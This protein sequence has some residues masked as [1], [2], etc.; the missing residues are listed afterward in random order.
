MK[1]NITKTIVIISA[2]TLFVWLSIIVFALYDFK[3]KDYV[4]EKGNIEVLTEEVAL[5][6]SGGLLIKEFSLEASQLKAIPYQPN[7]ALLAQNSSSKNE[8]SI[9]WYI[10]SN[11][12][13]PTHAWHL[14]TKITVREHD[15]LVKVSKP[16]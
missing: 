3:P 4:L 16:K 9:I 1:I 2:A 12:F 13:D 11:G 7:G 10:F 15:I 6:L 14:H 8:G 5:Q